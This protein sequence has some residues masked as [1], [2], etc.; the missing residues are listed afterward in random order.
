[1]KKDERSKIFKLPYLFKRL[2]DKY[3]IYPSDFNKMMINDIIY[4][5]KSHLVATFK[6]YL[7]IDDISEFLKRYYTKQESKSRLPKICEF[8]EKYCR[9]YPNYTS[10]YESKFIYKNIRRKQQAIDNE[11]DETSPARKKN[12]LSDNIFDT[13]INKSIENIKKP[14]YEK[15]STFNVCDK[16]D[17]S[18]LNILKFFNSNNSNTSDR[19]KVSKLPINTK[20][21]DGNK[22]KFT[23]ND[24]EIGFPGN[25]CLSSGVSPISKSKD[26]EARKQILIRHNHASSI[27][28]QS[29]L[30][31]QISAYP[32]NPKSKLQIS[33]T[34]N[35]RNSNIV[36]IVRDF[37]QSKKMNLNKKTINFKEFQSNITD[38]KPKKFLTIDTNN[39]LLNVNNLQFNST[40]KHVK[41]AFSLKL[42]KNSKHGREFSQVNDFANLA[43]HPHIIIPN[44]TTY[45]S[46]NNN[47]YTNNYTGNLPSRKERN[48]LSSSTKN[49]AK[50]NITMTPT[51]Y[52]RSKIKD[53][54]YMTI[55]STRASKKIE[56]KET[57]IKY[58]NLIEQKVISHLS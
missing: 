29:S 14:D 44:S 5:E 31:D 11:N 46:I 30:K 35:A 51:D 6:D 54:N 9:I 37:N 47:V 16:T 23:K 18:I 40:T 7:I 56:Q 1:M 2:G 41:G 55:S 43:D 4:N 26:F 45:V 19:K 57:K 12:I 49:K 32:K 38:R 21:L 48:H 28:S 13:Q 3:K 25:A 17:I 8:Y 39:D 50:K 15:S 34:A 10:I 27:N 42:E 36:E 58:T 20:I 22:S 53:I 52:I 24:N 33:N